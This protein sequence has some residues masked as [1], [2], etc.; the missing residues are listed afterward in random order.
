MHFWL[1]IEDDEIVLRE[2]EKTPEDTAQEAVPA[3]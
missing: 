2:G 1:D 3:V